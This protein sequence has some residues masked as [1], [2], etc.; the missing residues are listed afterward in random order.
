MKEL[1]DSRLVANPGVRSFG[2]WE[3]LERGWGEK[4]HLNTSWT[5][6]KKNIYIYVYIYI[7][8]HTLGARGFPD[9]EM[10]RSIS[11]VILKFTILFLPAP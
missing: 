11:K 4:F 3:A 9:R 10:G 5:I 7:Y 1:P 8:I 6:K 2:K